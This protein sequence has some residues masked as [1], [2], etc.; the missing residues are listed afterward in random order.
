MT[1]L[2]TSFLIDLL[3]ETAA[4]R[5][6]PALDLMEAFEDDELLGV[7]VFVV[8]ELRV[9]AELA[10]K[11][12]RE[13]EALDHLLSGLIVACPDARFAPAYGRLLATMQ[14]NGQRVATMDL[15]IATAAMIDDAQL[16]SRNIKDF[17]R[18]PG[19]RVIGY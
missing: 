15:L 9:G 14:R 18:I 19:L 2:D 16:V 1:H 10:R 5:P 12:L 6:G 8:S 3:R 17:S 4:G 11:P 13:N 7:S